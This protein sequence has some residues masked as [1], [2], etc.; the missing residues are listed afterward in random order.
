MPRPVP[1]NRSTKAAPTFSSRR[2]PAAPNQANRDRSQEQRDQFRNP[3]QTLSP[4]PARKPFRIAKRD[5]DE[6][7]VDEQCEKRE[8]NSHRIDQDQERG[9]QRRARDQR[10][11]QRHDTKFITAAAAAL[12]EADEFAHRETKEDQPSCDLKIRHR[13]SKRSKNNF[14]QKNEPDRHAKP[15]Q[16]PEHRL[17]LSIFGRSARPQSREDRNQP[18]RIDRN[19][20]RDKREKEFFQIRLHATVFACRVRFRKGAIVLYRF[21]RLHNFCFCA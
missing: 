5:R 11:S 4:H 15:G 3:A 13:N 16:D 7:K 18:D 10:H 12:A 14:A 17:M 8:Q 2:L 19:K 21:P 6:P 9:Q 20:K 1:M